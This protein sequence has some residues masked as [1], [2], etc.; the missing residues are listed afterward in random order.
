LQ[1]IDLVRSVGEVFNDL[2]VP[3]VLGGS[4]A[5]SLVG[6]PRSTV[7]IDVAVRLAQAKLDALIAELR[8]EFLVDR[9]EALRAIRQRGSFDALYLPSVLKIDVFVLGDDP[10]DVAQVER[11]RQYVVEGAS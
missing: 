3:W 5:S 9:D 8:E 11:R 7:D 10:L 2:D 4:I 1:P 6:E